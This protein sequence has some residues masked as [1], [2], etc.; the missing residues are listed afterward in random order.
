[1]TPEQ[2]H[3]E[4]LLEQLR[5]QTPM[6]VVVEWVDSITDNV[7]GMPM[8]GE[9]NVLLRLKRPVGS[10]SYGAALHELGHLSRYK[11]LRALEG[12]ADV[13]AWMMF[14]V[15]GFPPPPVVLDEEKAAWDWAEAHN[16][17]APERV[18]KAN[19][20]YALRTYGVVE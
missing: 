4:E 13:T 3:V 18:M 12:R 14:Q 20:R 19:R 1:M 11:E 10:L 7:I 5:K 15:L 17:L 8:A 9:P 16:K 6:P 2:A